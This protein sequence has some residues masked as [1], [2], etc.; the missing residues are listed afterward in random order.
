MKYL[1]HP[2]SD[3]ISIPWEDFI[4]EHMKHHSSTVDLLQQGEFG[5]DPE[6]P[7]Y[8][9]MENKYAYLTILL[10]AVVDHLPLGM[11]LSPRVVGDR[12]WPRILALRFLVRQMWL[13][14]GLDVHHEFHP[15]ASLES[16]PRNRSREN[17]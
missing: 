15:L 13:W 1:T 10:V 3:F 4:L 14:L 16:F 11:R 5:W 9:L 7:L 8:W 17:L 6:K 2:F 12:S